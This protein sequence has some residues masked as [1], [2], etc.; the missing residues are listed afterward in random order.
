[1]AIITKPIT[2]PTEYNIDLGDRF[3]DRSVYVKVPI[4]KEEKAMFL[5][6][7]YIRN[8]I[9]FLTNADPSTMFYTIEASF[10]LSPNEPKLKTSG[11]VS[12]LDPDTDA[13]RLCDYKE[14][15]IYLLIDKVQTYYEVRDIKEDAN[16]P[17]QFCC[18]KLPDEV[19]RTLGIC[20]VSA[21]TKPRWTKGLPP[22]KKV[23]VYNNRVV[24][25]TFIDD[26]FTKS[27]CSENDAFDLDVGIT[28]CTLKRL[29]GTNSDNATKQ[30]SKFIKHVH[31]VMEEN[32]LKEDAEKARK[33]SEKAK[34]RKIELKKAAEKLKAKE[35][36]I[37]I[38]K[39]AYI[40]AMR[41]MTEDD[42]K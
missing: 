27:V 36:Q 1:M 21:T 4:G 14:K 15:L 26:T 3:G 39:Q 18:E 22:V 31:K 35:E 25:V 9:I 13:K 6:P 11:M 12:M 30:Y 10:R 29:L 33:A 34:R 23:E 2:K 37:D 40:R 28:I 5:T 7:N 38:Q 41:E 16:M 42:L 17:V 24:K 20:R 8:R 32:A 19:L